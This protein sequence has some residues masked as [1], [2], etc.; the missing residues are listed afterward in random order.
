VIVGFLGCVAVV[1][2]C[3][4]GAAAVRVR[5]LEVAGDLDNPVYVASPEGDPRL[6]VVEQAGRIR[7][8]SGGRMLPAPFLD[9]TDRVSYGGER[10]LLSVAFHPRYAENGS[11]YVNYTDRSGDTRVERYRVS[12]DPNRADPATAAL[13]LAVDQPYANHNGGHILFGPDGML[14]VGM[15]DGGSGGDP[16]GNGQNLG[17]LLG[18]ILRLNVDREGGGYGIPADNPFVGD[19]QARPEV[20]AWGLRNPWRM[21]FDAA[22]GLL[23]IAD[24]GQNQWEEIHVIS[25]SRGGLNLGWNT[26]EGA[27]C[28]RI[29]G[30]ETAGLDLPALEYP[31]SQGCSVT[32]GFVYRGTALPAMVGHYVYADYCQ[33]WVRSFLYREGRVT[34][35]RDVD[36]GWLGRILSFGEDAEGE[37]YV[38]SDNG[39]VYR[40]GPG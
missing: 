30:C 25:A 20:W 23:Y 34:Q 40:L 15:G 5:A 38:L 39:S 9:L 29:Q 24:V 6:F 35:T 33:G 16:R 14:Y 12:A 27:H 21:D 10:G 18:K 22:T 32:G 26:M 4:Q 37:L 8:L 17:S 28:F 7:I 3:A 31:H 11:F 1:A 13:V 19:P 36:V 2:A